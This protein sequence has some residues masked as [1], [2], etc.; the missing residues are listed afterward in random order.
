[1]GYLYWLEQVGQ[2]HNELVGKKCAN[3]G[4][5]ARMGLPVP[6]GF[7]ICIDGYKAYIEN[8]GIKEELSRYFDS[9]GDLREGGVKVFDKVSQDVRAIIESREIPGDLGDEISSYYK[10]LCEK[11]GIP[12][13]GVSVRSAGVE[14]RPGMFETY[15]NVKGEE[16]L[17]LEIKKVW[18]SAF[19]PR[20]IAFRASKGLPIDADMLGVAVLKMVNARAAGVSFSIEPSSGDASKMVTEAVWGLGEGV[21]SGAESVDMFVLDKETLEVLEAHI[22]KKDRYMVI[23]GSG[24]DWEGVPA[25]KQSAPCLTDE[26]VRKIGE[27]TKILEER[28]GRPQDVEWAVD[29]DFPF[30]SSIFLLQTRPAKIAVK[31]TSEQLTERLTKV[32]REMDTSK[33][34]MEKPD[35]RF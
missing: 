20:A 21:V 32:F 11:V 18:S 30:P 16:E 17:L 28:L 7:V 24:V 8:T 1:M 2:E 5:M 14:S 12:N 33:M 31:S 35:F 29:C 3:L 9:L 10:S 19:A 23:K 25:D 6:P 15:L 13:L 4:Q 34:R 22:A 27:L 26:E